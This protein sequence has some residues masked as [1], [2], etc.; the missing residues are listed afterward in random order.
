M[1]PCHSVTPFNIVQLSHMD[2]CQTGGLSI[3]QG[4][5]GVTLSPCHRV[6]KSPMPL[7]GDS[8][9]PHVHCQTDTPS[10]TTGKGRD[11]SDS[12]NGPRCRCRG[13]KFIFMK[14]KT[15]IMD[16]HDRHEGG[17]AVQE[18]PAGAGRQAWPPGQQRLRWGWFSNIYYLN[19]N[20]KTKQM[21]TTNTPYL[22]SVQICTEI[23]FWEFDRWNIFFK[24]TQYSKYNVNLENENTFQVNTIF[25]STGKKFWETNPTETWD[26]INGWELF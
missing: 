26:M 11:C 9:C 10:T 17:E 21:N 13:G 12:S 7:N 1:S 6:P 22:N 20:L 24:W 14:I 25:T 4:D 18:D 15:K 23:P 2:P 19:L 16:D 3:V 5:Q 8:P